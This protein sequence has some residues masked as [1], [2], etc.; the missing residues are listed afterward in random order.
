MITPMKPPLLVLAT[1]LTTIACRSAGAHPGPGIVVSQDGTVY[2]AY[3]PSHRIWK[4]HPDGQAVPL[5]TGGLEKP[6]RVPHHLMIDA[7]DRIYT[8]SDAGSRVWRIT[9]DGSMKQ[10]YPPE[11]RDATGVVGSGGDPFTI[12]P[13][14][15]IVAASSTRRESRVLSIP[16]AGEPSL[17]AGGPVGFV[18]GPRDEARFGNLHGSCFAWGGAGELYL[19]DNGVRVR[20]IATDGGVTTVAG[21][22]ERAYR[23]GPGAEARFERACGLVVAPDGFIFVADGRR[24]RRIAPDGT[25]TTIAGSGQRGGRDGRG[26]EATFDDAVGVAL[27]EAGNLF[28]LEYAREEKGEV[29]R[30]RRVDAMG[31]VGTY[32]RIEEP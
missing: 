15:R 30:V 11:D 29:L 21:G 12:G 24:I 13:D 17:V 25:V 5:V 23:D 26:V 9:P 27:D 32:A 3:G 10:L 20:R 28:V 2:I 18:D 1:L 7:Q 14:G 6:F 16:L 22:A 8:V 4:I 31:E 19:T